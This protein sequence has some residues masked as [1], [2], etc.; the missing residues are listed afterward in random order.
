MIVPITSV[1]Q[2]L[3]IFIA[4]AAGSVLLPCL[5]WRLTGNCVTSMIDIKY[6]SKHLSNI[7]LPYWHWRTCCQALD[8]IINMEKHKSAANDAPVV[9]EMVYMIK[10]VTVTL[11]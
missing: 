7:Y 1:P 4:I 6:C 8:R 5:V 9:T 10:R 11:H 3:I 2:G